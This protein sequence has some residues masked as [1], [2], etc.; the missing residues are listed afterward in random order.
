MP[1][2]G[3]HG[4]DPA[5]LFGGGPGTYGVEYTDQMINDYLQGASGGEIRHRD[6]VGHGTHVASIAAGNGQPD[7]K[8][9]GV[10]PEAD[11]I[12]VKYLALET[13]P[14]AGGQVVDWS[15]RLFDA[16]SYI[17]NVAQ[18]DYAGRRVVINCSFG[19][20]TGAHDGFSDEEDSLTTTFAGRTGQILVS[21]AGNDAGSNQHASIEFPAGGG[22]VTIPCDLFDKRTNPLEYDK[23]QWLNLTTELDIDMYYPDGPTISVELQ[24]PGGAPFKAGPA[25][26]G[27]NVTGTIGPQTYTLFHLRDDQLLRSGVTVKR[28]V[29]RIEIEPKNFIHCV[30]RYLVKVTT[31]DKVTIHMWCHQPG[32]YGL[33]IVDDDPQNPLP[34]TVHVTDLFQIG[35][36]A[37]AANIITV[38]AYNAEVAGLDIANFSSRGPIARHDT[39]APAQ[40]V[41]PDLAAPGVSVDAAHSHDTRPK[42][43]KTPT[44]AFNGT[45]MAS[46]H[47]AGVVALMLQKANLTVAQ[48]LAKLTA[49]CRTTPPATA[50][51]AGAGRLNAKA[52]VDDTP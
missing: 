14:K 28:N 25:L 33:T 30:G 11:L 2:A 24:V 17:L 1:E 47:V 27:G 44:V 12:M 38:A 35:E 29:F 43:K 13:E 6:C 26:G 40:P 20:D 45:S 3:E 49:H 50:E 10:A 23:C 37:G 51:E 39:N 34:N 41:K 5:R 18:N 36:N 15:K 46:P 4:P 22:T 52:T 9:V 8:Y 31:T 19:S 7:Y 32:E 16:V 42:Q 21:S 48:A